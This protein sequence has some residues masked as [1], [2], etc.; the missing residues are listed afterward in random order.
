MQTGLLQGDVSKRNEHKDL[1]PRIGKIGQR[2]TQEQIGLIDRF[3]HHRQKCQNKTKR[4]NVPKL[5]LRT[6]HEIIPHQKRPH[7]PPKPSLSTQTRHKKSKTQ[8]ELL[9]SKKNQFQ[10][11]RP[12]SKLRTFSDIKNFLGSSRALILISPLIISVVT[13]DTNGDQQ[14]GR[15][16]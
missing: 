1:M 6:N 5:M 7:Y 16:G 2:I 4:E 9:L 10:N 11:N 13:K 15:S 8:I 14:V 3:S 12:Y